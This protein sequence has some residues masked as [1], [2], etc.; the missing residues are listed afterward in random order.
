MIHCDQERPGLLVIGVVGHH[1]MRRR[2][3]SATVVDDLLDFL[4][5]A[6]IEVPGV[7]GL[8]AGV[9]VFHRNLLSGPIAERKLLRALS[10]PGHAVPCDADR[11]QQPV[12]IVHEYRIEGLDGVALLLELRALVGRLDLFTVLVFAVIRDSVGLGAPFPTAGSLADRG[13]DIPSVSNAFD[14]P[15]RIKTIDFGNVDRRRALLRLRRRW[16]KQQRAKR[17]QADHMGSRVPAHVRNKAA[18]M[19]LPRVVDPLASTGPR[20]GSGVTFTYS[21]GSCLL[22]DAFSRCELSRSHAT[23]F[24]ARLTWARSQTRANASGGER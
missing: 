22:L 16:Q 21:L 17:Q 1:Q 6:D 7:A 18:H 5:G 23:N 10:G 19:W 20:P 9:G 24:A 15:Q 13:I 12:L 4:V 11:E 14:L 2:G 3:R 8:V